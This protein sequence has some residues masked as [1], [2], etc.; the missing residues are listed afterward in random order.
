MI[1]EGFGRER[2]DSVA[3][4]LHSRVGAAI[5]AETFDIIHGSD[6]YAC[7]SWRLN[8]C[9]ARELFVEQPGSAIAPFIL[10][11]GIYFQDAVRATAGDNGSA[12]GALATHRPALQALGA[13][14]TFTPASGTRDDR[15]FGWSD[16]HL[17]EWLTGAS[18][19]RD[20]V[21]LWDFRKGEPELQK[22]EEVL[23]A[24]HPVWL[25]WNALP[26]LKEEH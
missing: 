26:R 1:T 21:W 2:F 22:L 18:D 5:P 17:T 16:Q 23:T 12:F 3:H 15:V 25:S 6:N 4:Q 24:L 9:G 19:N 8:Q 13:C 10:R 14:C 11:V 7:A 20:L